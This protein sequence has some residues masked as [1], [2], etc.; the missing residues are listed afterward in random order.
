MSVVHLSFLPGGPSPLLYQLPR[1]IDEDYQHVCP[2]VDSI[3]L[4][5]VSTGTA[6][7]QRRRRQARIQRMPA[8]PHLFNKTGHTTPRR[9][10]GAPQRMCVTYDW[11][12]FGLAD[13]VQTQMAKAG[14]IYNPQILKDDN[15]LCAYCGV[16]LHNWEPED[17]PL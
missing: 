10:V 15:A 4:I 11:L 2:F 13:I 12:C 14:F 9:L 8:L 17:D 7:T 16:S 5:T 6:Q 1:T 3:Q